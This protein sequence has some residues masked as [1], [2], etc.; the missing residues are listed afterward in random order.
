MALG[1]SWGVGRGQA[2]LVSAQV[3][4]PEP[5]RFNAQDAHVIIT[6]LLD[7][8]KVRLSAKSIHSTNIC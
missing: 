7:P 2:L 3:N 1:F 4:I 5:D 8:G 6:P